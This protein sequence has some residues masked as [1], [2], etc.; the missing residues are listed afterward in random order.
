VHCGDGTGKIFY[1]DDSVLLIS[2]HRFDNGCFYPGPFGS[3]ENIGEG[4]GEGFNVFFGFS[5][6]D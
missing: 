3:H 4:K 2:L 6:K 5:T 1:K